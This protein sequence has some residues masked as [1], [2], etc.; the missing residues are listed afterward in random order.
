ML[1]IVVWGINSYYTSMGFTSQKYKLYSRLI[2]REF[3]YGRMYTGSVGFLLPG[4]ALLS[5]RMW[6]TFL[7]CV[8]YCLYK[9]S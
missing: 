4:R 6:F 5:L 2:Q 9:P 1:L 8:C 7:A 3:R